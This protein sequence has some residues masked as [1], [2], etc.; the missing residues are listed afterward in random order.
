EKIIAS[1]IS[2]EAGADF[3]KTSTGFSKG[4]ATLFDVVL[5][6]YA[7]DGKIKVKASGGI[8]SREDALRM[9][10][11]GASRIGTSSGVKILRGESGSAAY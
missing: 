4:G 2:K 5:M 11:A 7:V 6:N 10:A 8:R 9:I 3:I 1:I